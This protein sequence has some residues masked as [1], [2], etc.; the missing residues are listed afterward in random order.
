MLHFPGKRKKK[1]RFADDVIASDTKISFVFTGLS[2]LIILGSLLAST[3]MGG[4]ISDRIGVLLLIAIVMAVTGLI[5]GG[6]AYRSA[7]GDNNAKRLSVLLS[8]VALALLLV[9]G[10]I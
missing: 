4:K 7:E 9:I 1:Y 3:I 2:L 10:I 5:F 8:V 6:L